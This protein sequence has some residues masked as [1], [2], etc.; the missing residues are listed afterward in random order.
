MK[1]EELFTKYVNIISF[2]KEKDENNVTHSLIVLKMGDD[3]VL[4]ENHDE[5]Y[6]FSNE[7]KELVVYTKNSMDELLDYVIENIINYNIELKNKKELLN[8]KI[9]EIE[10]LF[11]NKK[12]DEL[13][14]ISIKI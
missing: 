11:N 5:N 6:Q 13:K 7:D 1:L 3:W 4:P 12:F 2:S 14:N 9:K 10:T 8:N